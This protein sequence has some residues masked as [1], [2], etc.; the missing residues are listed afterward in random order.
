M[1]K[2]TGSSPV[3]MRGRNKYSGFRSF[4][5]IPEAEFSK[6]GQFD[7]E[8]IGIKADGAACDMKL[9]TFFQRQRGAEISI[10]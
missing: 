2:M 5:Q 7:C 6:G 9:K 4:N 8:V 10:Y 1:E 3:M